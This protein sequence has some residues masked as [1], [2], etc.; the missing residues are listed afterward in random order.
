M[1]K[2]FVFFVSPL[3]TI[4]DQFEQTAIEQEISTHVH[5]VRVHREKITELS[6]ENSELLLRNQANSK[7]IVDVG[8][9]TPFCYPFKH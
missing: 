8:L 1:L 7:H 9:L 5:L 6:R 2:S 4:T 3:C